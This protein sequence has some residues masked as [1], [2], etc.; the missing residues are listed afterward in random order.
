MDKNI[1]ISG[2]SEL[3]IG[4]FG[5]EKKIAKSNTCPIYGKTTR[6]T[7][8]RSLF[9]IY[10]DTE[11]KMYDISCNKKVHSKMC[12]WSNREYPEAVTH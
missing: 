4:C 7:S 10:I 6:K 1:N 3:V 8:H 12:S 5:N 9:R 11:F 2:I